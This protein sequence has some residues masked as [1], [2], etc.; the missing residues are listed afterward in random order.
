MWTVACFWPGY[1]EL[2]Q[3][4]DV[5]AHRNRRPL[6]WAEQGIP[7]IWWRSVLVSAYISIRRAVFRQAN[8]T[9]YAHCNAPIGFSTHEAKTRGL[10]LA[11]SST[12][13]HFEHVGLC[14]DQT[15][16]SVVRMGQVIDG[17]VTLAK[18]A[19]WTL[20]RKSVV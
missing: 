14:C 4:L 19:G 6:G 7:L 18:E 11:F 1:G 2:R 8:E 17:A 12:L 5:S 13:V 3:E 15:L 10:M 9:A 20:D 16:D